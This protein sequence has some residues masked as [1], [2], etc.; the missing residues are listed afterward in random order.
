MR[1]RI[2]FQKT[3]VTIYT[4]ALDLQK[5]WERSLRRAQLVVRYSEGFHPQPKMQLAV[6]LPVG[7]I[8]KEELIDIWFVNEYSIVELLE[9]LQKALPEGIKLIS[10]NEIPENQKALN[11]MSE[12]AEFV[13]NIRD[14]EVSASYLEKSIQSL[15]D[16]KAIE[17]ERNKKH[18]DLRPLIL[19]MNIFNA[20]NSHPEI[21]MHLLASSGAT[22]RPDEVLKEL[23][24]D[25][26]LCEIER[27]RINFKK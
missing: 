11:G 7:F 16:K 27:I 24:I 22:G 12:S 25:P 17:R 6:P 3:G 14:A 18:Y 26:A 13:V 8:G 21:Y 19:S 20:N 1:L 15:L 9:R 5:I 10:I 23:G 4:S 2:T